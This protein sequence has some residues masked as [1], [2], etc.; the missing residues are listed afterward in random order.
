MAAPLSGG[1][2][3]NG[4]AAVI[5]SLAG[6]SDQQLTGPI[7]IAA[8]FAGRVEEPQLTGIVKG[9][10]LVY[11]NETYGTRLSALK[12]DGRFTNDQFVINTLSAT[13]GSG[14]VSAQGSVGLSSAQ[15]F[16]VNITADLNDARL[17]RSDSLA[18][19]A[20]GKIKVTHDAKGGLIEGTLSIPEAR[21]EVIRQGAAEVSQLTGVR[22]KG[23]ALQTAEQRA[24]AESMGTFALKL[25]IR[26]DNQLFISG[27]GLESEWAATINIG[28]TSANPVVGGNATIVRGTYD[29][30]GRR[31]D[32]TRGTIR[33]AGS[34]LT[35]PTIDIGATTTTEGVTAILNVTGTAEAPRIA[36]TSTPALP[37]E[38]VLSRILFGSTV[39]NLNATEAIQ[40]AAALNS[41]RGQGG[42]LN[43]LGKLRSA[44]GIDRLR[45][46]SADETTGRGTALSAGKYITNDIYVEIITD[47]RGY[48]ATQLEVALSR[49]LSILSQTGSFGG[50]SVSVKYSKDY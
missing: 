22:R 41:L 31:F 33:F 16:P 49:A 8:D 28:G 21:Y 44:T 35:N 25:R 30:A 36:F 5:F 46:L 17:A 43:P 42:G 38:E 45:I 14:T 10:N 29:F 13:A 1:V 3:Y 7:G 39:T 40:L 23:Q 18:A 48:T 34:R 4:P 15:G 6:L 12:I 26:A 24:A 19:T 47:A 27:M 9:N 50:S 37:Q 2:R 20:T 32:I 11:E